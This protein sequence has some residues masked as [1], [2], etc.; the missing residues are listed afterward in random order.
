MVSRREELTVVNHAL[1]FILIL[2]RCYTPEFI[3]PFWWS[4]LTKV[5]QEKKKRERNRSGRLPRV[6]REVKRIKITKMR[7]AYILVII[8]DR[9][10]IF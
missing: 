8:G 10:P 4:R 7:V 5:S 3:Y 6:K 2:E 9:S 1:V